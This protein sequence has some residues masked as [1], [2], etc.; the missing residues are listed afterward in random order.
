MNKFPYCVIVRRI[1]LPHSY[2]AAQELSRAA[3]LGA[4]SERSRCYPSGMNSNGRKKGSIT[5][6]L[7]RDVVDPRKQK[8]K[9]VKEDP[10]VTSNPLNPP[11]L[12]QDEGGGYNPDYTFPQE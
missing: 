6:P 8:S 7:L 4:F 10:S 3:R 9:I 5:K 1:R 12:Y 2:L 11:D